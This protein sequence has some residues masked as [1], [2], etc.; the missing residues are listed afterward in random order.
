MLSWLSPRSK[1]MAANSL[2]SAP[3]CQINLLRNPAALLRTC[4]TLHARRTSPDHAGVAHASEA[5]RQSGRGPRARVGLDLAGCLGR[6]RSKSPDPVLR[7]RPD[8]FEAAAREL[9]DRPHRRTGSRW[10]GSPLCPAAARG[11]AD[12]RALLRRG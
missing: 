10:A 12:Q 4:V 1:L 3:V 5:I 9:G 11:P 2:A 8:V 6:S 7:V